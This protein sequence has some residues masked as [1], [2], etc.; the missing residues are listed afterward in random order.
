MSAY[1]PATLVTPTTG[2]TVTGGKIIKPCAQYLGYSGATGPSYT[3]NSTLPMQMSSFGNVTTNIENL[4]G[5]ISSSGLFTPPLSGTY[6]FSIA[7]TWGGFV[8]TAGQVIFRFD[9][10]RSGS[11]ISTIYKQMFINYL[12][13]M[14]DLVVYLPI[15]TTMQISIINYNT[16]TAGTLTG[17]NFHIT[18]M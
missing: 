10:I 15:G 18:Q 16:N 11:T 13:D 2:L 4:A 9:F 6:V 8:P 5:A 17:S 3:S 7:G 1:Y 12:Y 14:M